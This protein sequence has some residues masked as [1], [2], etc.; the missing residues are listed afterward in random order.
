MAKAKNKLKKIAETL[1]TVCA[2]LCAFLLVF[3]A[4][5]GKKKNE[6]AYVFGYAVLRVETGSM[7]SAIPAKSYILV[8]KYKGE[9]LAA[10][11]IA[12]YRMRD[13]SSTAYGSLITHR[14]EKVTA[15]GYVFKGDNNPA[16]DGAAV[17]SGDIVAVYAK[18]LPVLT[19]FGRV[20]ASPLGLVSLIALFVCVC[21]FV[22]V[23]EMVGVLNAD[24]E[25]KKQRLF[26]ER[27]QEEVRKL[28]EEDEKRRAQ[29]TEQARREAF[30]NT[31]GNGTD[32]GKQV[33]DEKFSEKK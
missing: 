20:Y 33:D 11:D 23:P 12:S 30:R 5:A 28:K 16:A 19:F 15:E 31:A 14:V 22:Y 18:N 8:K 27:V 4:I 29:S 26:D 25:E 1:P 6:P 9:E 10:G 13:T 7:E 32:D 2:V 24:K 17:Q 21:V 3:A